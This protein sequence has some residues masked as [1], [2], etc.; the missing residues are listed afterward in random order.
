MPSFR[1]II[2]WDACVFLSYI[3][4]TPERMPI[5]E[6]L[7]AESRRSNDLQIVT[8]ELS[9]T[10]VAFAQYERDKKTLDPAVERAINTMWDDLS[11][12]RTVDV[13]QLLTGEARQFMRLSLPAGL[14]LKPADAIH[15]AT[16]KWIGATV[17]HTYDNKLKNYDGLVG[18]PVEEPAIEQPTLPGVSP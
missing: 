6:A 16:A 11:A 12:I 18:C 14:S 4:G 8:S 3:E 17:F 9:R 13:H 15:L 5:L 7:L 1:K 2:Y 10:E